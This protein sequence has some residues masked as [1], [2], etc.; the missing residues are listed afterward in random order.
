M[1]WRDTTALERKGN[2][3]NSILVGKSVT[4]HPFAGTLS[5]G[6]L[7]NIRRQKNVTY[8]YYDVFIGDKFSPSATVEQEVRALILRSD[9][10]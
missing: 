9:K 8:K 1:F 7:I 2:W 6:Y 5:G 10:V 3:K 4:V